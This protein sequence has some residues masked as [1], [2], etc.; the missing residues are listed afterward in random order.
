MV[1]Q[2][3]EKE[4][5]IALTEIVI[6]QDPGY[7]SIIKNIL[8]KFRKLGCNVSIKIHYIFMYILTILM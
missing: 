1:I 8:D 3:D 2:K 4:A 6:R 7:K 5:F